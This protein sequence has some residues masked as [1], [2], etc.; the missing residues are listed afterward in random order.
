MWN[1]QFSYMVQCIF[2]RFVHGVPVEHTVLGIIGCKF[3]ETR[4][5]AKFVPSP[6]NNNLLKLTH[7]C[8]RS[9]IVPC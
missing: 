3:C 5:Y 2:A 7:A 8:M 6:K 4:Y 1:S 9:S